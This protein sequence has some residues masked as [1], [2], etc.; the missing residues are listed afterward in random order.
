MPFLLSL[1]AIA[2]TLS[3]FAAADPACQ[4]TLA[5]YNPNLR[6]MCVNA[7]KNHEFRDADLY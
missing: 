3:S 7:S 4:N 6:T 1:F 5:I 2:A